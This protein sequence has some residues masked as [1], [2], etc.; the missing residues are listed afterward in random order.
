MSVKSLLC[1]SLRLAVGAFLL[2]ACAPT[3][4]SRVSTHVWPAHGNQYYNY[5]DAKYLGSD[6]AATISYRLIDSQTYNDIWRSYNGAFD[7]ANAI[8]SLVESSHLIRIDSNGIQ[9]DL[10]WV[11]DST[12]ITGR[13][14]QVYLFIDRTTGVIHPGPPRWDHPSSDVTR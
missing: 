3:G 8:R 14:Y 4:A 13:E 10:Q 11:G 2:P 1:S 9:A 5:W 7:D 12:V 6:C